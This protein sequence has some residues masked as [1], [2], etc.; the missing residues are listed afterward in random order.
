MIFFSLRTCTE[1]EATGNWSARTGRQPHSWLRRDHF[2]SLLFF[3][4]R[5]Q[6]VKTCTRRARPLPSPQ[7]QSGP[8]PATEHGG[9]SYCEKLL[10]IK[11]VPYFNSLRRKVT[12]FV[13]K[14]MLRKKVGRRQAIYKKAWGLGES[15]SR[16]EDLTSGSGGSDLMARGLGTQSP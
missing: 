9:L 4:R 8:T 13:F 12:L 10:S 2:K 1:F 3:L 5:Y 15:P 7:L 16:E 11:P 6:A 14:W